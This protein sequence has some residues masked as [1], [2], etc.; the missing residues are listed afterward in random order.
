MCCYP[1]KGAC[2][3]R[4]PLCGVI[5]KAYLTD[6]CPSEAGKLYVHFADGDKGSTEN[7]RQW[8]EQQVI[9]NISLFNK[10]L[11]DSRRASY[12]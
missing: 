7:C 11:Y 3:L 5:E 2:A 6:R 12:L 9:D 1:Y 4:A 8:I 10:P